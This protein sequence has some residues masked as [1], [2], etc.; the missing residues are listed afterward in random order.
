MQQIAT[1]AVWAGVVLQAVTY[2]S[3]FLEGQRCKLGGTLEF[4]Q[5]DWGLNLKSF[6]FFFL[7][8][9]GSYF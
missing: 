6:F 5:D 9:K 2:I 1:G 3:F 8:P 7:G 4:S